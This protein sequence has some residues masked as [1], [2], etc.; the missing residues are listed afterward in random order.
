MLLNKYTVFKL[1]FTLMSL[2]F[3]TPQKVITVV[4]PGRSFKAGNLSEQRGGVTFEHKM[5]IT[6]TP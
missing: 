5:H 1:T 2:T 3:E 4:T 6:N